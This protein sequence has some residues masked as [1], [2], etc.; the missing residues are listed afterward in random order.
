ML[1]MDGDGRGIHA[2][3]ALPTKADIL[4]GG[5]DVR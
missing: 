5:L 4:L 3:L 2:V 1:R